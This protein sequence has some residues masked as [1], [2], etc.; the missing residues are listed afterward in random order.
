MSPA[1]PQAQP[2]AAVDAAARS[3]PPGSYIGA[4]WPTPRRGGGRGRSRARPKCGGGRRGARR[5]QPGRA[6]APRSE[7]P[8]VAGAGVG[9]GELRGGGGGPAAAAGR[10]EALPDPESPFLRGSWE[11]PGPP[12]VGVEKVLEAA[13]PRWRPRLPA[14]PGPAPGPPRGRAADITGGNAFLRRRQASPGALFV[15]KAGACIWDVPER[16]LSV[17]PRSVCVA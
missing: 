3:R 17:G 8:A 4:G 6:V 16:C 9:V 14:R 7:R 5:C 2:P 10:P 15:L 1:T 11:D 13:G 12:Y